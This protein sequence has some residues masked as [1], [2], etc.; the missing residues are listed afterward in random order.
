MVGFCHLGVERNRALV[1]DASLFGL[2]QC[3]VNVSELKV[4]V[5]KFGLVGDNLLQGRNGGFKFLLVNV[6][7]RF[8]Q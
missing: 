5:S 1:L 8:I 6:A 3:G 7:L 2:F 4:R